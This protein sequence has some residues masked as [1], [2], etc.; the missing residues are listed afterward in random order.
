MTNEDVS[1]VPF[2]HF[3]QWCHEN[4]LNPIEEVKKIDAKGYYIMN[5]MTYLIGDSDKHDGNWGFFRDN[6]TGKLLGLHPLFDFNN[7]FD[8]Y[9]L[10][11]GGICIPEIIP[12]TDSDYPPF[13]VTKSQKEA[14]LEGIKHVQLIQKYK[15]AEEMFLT[16]ND[17]A[18]FCNRC[19]DL[20][21]EISIGSKVSLEQCISEKE[22][23]RKFLHNIDKE[24][25]KEEIRKN[26]DETTYM[27]QEHLM[28]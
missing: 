19:S 6:D 10:K 7:A 25:D 21:I 23:K 12:N 3:K 16:E 11:D 14:A 8:N 2:R 18:V 20:G 22:F 4:N 26:L 13:I 1:I 28:A 9:N 15:I 24:N 5:I 17:F 27:K